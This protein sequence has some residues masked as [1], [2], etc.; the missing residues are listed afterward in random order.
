VPFKFTGNLKRVLIGLT[1]VKL[2]PADEE[3]IRRARAAIG[4]AQ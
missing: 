4:V 3:E 1:D 2:T